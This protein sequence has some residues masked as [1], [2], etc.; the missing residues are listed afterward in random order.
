MTG[1]TF[2]K[3]CEQWGFRVC[4]TQAILLLGTHT[5]FHIYHIDS[6]WDNL[7]N[8]SE[9]ELDSLDETSLDEILFSLSLTHTFLSSTKTT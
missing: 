6:P 1:Q 9:K 3:Q 7:L 2:K 8:F 5:T 4:T